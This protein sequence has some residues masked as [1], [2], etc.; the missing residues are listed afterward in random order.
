MSCIEALL[1]AGASV[2]KKNCDGA[3]PLLIACD[4][5]L[6]DDNSQLD[7]ICRTLIDHNANVNAQDKDGNTPLLL[8]CQMSGM[9]DLIQY[10]IERGANLNARTAD[11]IR[12][13]H[14]AL[15]EGQYDVAKILVE[16]GAQINHETSEGY[17]TLH[18]AA[19]RANIP[20]ARY[21]LLNGVK[22]DAMA[23]DGS[24]ALTIAKKGQNHEFESFLRN[25]F[26]AK[27]IDVFSIVEDQIEHEGRR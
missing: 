1:S 4:A 27:D 17:T 23:N 26:G 21:F 12:P 24:T 2:Y 20:W 13:I 18:L 7:S 11:F 8:L 19:L 9:A 25:E 16:N 14:M 6:N 10:F 22:L 15:Q 5:Q 3:T